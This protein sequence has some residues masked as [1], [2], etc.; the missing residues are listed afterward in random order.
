MP[1]TGLAKR[2][3]VKLVPEK[4]TGKIYDLGSGWGTL[5]FPLSKRCPKAQIVGLE[6]SVIPY[7]VSKLWLALSGRKNIKILYQ[8]IY[9]A[10]LKDAAVI[11]CYLY[12]GAMQRLRKKFEKELKPGTLIVSNTFSVP[13]WKPEQVIELESLYRTNIYLYRV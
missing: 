7:L 3:V 8:D 6:T 11:A 13:G 12:P 10:E 1:S 5:L 4:T 2:T 9:E